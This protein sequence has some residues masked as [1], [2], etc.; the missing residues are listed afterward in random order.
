MTESL[1]V[2]FPQGKTLNIRDV[3]LTIKPFKFGELPKVFK[4]V[5]PI[6]GVLMEAMQ[7]RTNQFEMMSKILADA[8]EIGRAHV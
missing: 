2:M 8:G 4:A 1:N 6:F 7:S 5:D 3:N